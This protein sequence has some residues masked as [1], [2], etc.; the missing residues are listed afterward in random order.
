MK[1]LDSNCSPDL[2]R[3]NIELLLLYLTN[4]MKA[5]YGYQL[6]KE[7]EKRSNGFFRCKEG[8]IYPSLRKL[9]GDGLTRGEWQ[10]LPNGQRRRYYRLTKE[11]EKALAEKLDSW[12]LF[13]TSVN[14][15]FRQLEA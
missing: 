6:I 14:L 13:T 5:A 10:E 9:E 3:G 7:I 8:T 2:L 12:K 1:K 4:E 11:G 15:V